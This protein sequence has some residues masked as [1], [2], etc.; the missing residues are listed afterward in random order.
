MHAWTYDIKKSIAS[1]VNLFSQGKIWLLIVYKK[2][3]FE[4][5]SYK[6]N[7]VRDDNRPVTILKNVGT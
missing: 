3:L 7:C 4:A 1:H 5:I 6:Y 2:I